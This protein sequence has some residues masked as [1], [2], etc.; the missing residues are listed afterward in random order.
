MSRGYRK[1]IPSLRTF[2]ENTKYLKAITNVIKKILPVNFKGTI[3]SKFNPGTNHLEFTT[4]LGLLTYLRPPKLFEY[5]ENQIS[6]WSTK[7]ASFLSLMTPR[8]AT[9]PVPI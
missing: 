2:L 5:E 8:V 3:R 9:I 1:I 4:I 6:E 7:V